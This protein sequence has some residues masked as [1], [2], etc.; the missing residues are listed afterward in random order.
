MTSSLLEKDN[1]HF[2]TS[3]SSIFCSSTS[4]LFSFL[5]VH[6][7]CT[8][9]KKQTYP[10]YPLLYFPPLLPLPF[11]FFLPS[12]NP[13]KRNYMTHT[14]PYLVGS[15]TLMAL[16]RTCARKGVGWCGVVW[17]GVGWCV[18]K[19]KSGHFLSSSF[20]SLSFFFLFFLFLFLFF[21][22]SLFI[23]WCAHKT[24]FICIFFSR[25]RRVN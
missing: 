1:Y 5:Y 21:F 4:F 11:P 8:W 14:S 16:V 7:C 25:E 20:L 3:R 22:S 24:L 23:V 12:I 9:I 6:I 15:S 17:G 19:K 10:F 2:H 13:K 18:G